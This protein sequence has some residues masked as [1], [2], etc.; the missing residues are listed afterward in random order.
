MIYSIQSYLENY[1]N[2]CGLA[3]PDQYAVSLAKVYDRQRSGKTAPAFLFTMKRMRTGFY[4]Q[5]EHIKRPAFERRILTLLDNKFKKK[6][7]SSCQTQSPRNLRHRA[8]A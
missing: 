6:D 7:F 2:R 3:D 5:N 1:F 4:R 8:I